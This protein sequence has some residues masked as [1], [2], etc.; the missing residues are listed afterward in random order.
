MTTWR[1]YFL[2]V[3][4]CSKCGDYYDGS[5]GTEEYNRN[6]GVPKEDR[7]CAKQQCID[8]LAADPNVKRETARTIDRGIMAAMGGGQSK[9][10]K[11]DP[12]RA[13]ML[14]NSE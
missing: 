8:L 7:T 14:V 3:P 4:D 12:I 9:P 13:G 10:L 6:A 11:R 2:S 1:F 5:F